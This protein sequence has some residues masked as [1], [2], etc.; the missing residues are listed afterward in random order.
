[1]SKRAETGNST[2][3]TKLNAV[4]CGRKVALEEALDTEIK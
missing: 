3:V 1:M 2:E 4:K